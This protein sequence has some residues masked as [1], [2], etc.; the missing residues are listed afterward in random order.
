VKP[1]KLSLSE[2]LYRKRIALEELSSKLSR[3]SIVK[4]RND[5]HARRLPRPCGITVHVALGCTY[6]CAYCYV[7]DMGFS[8]R[9]Y[10]LYGLNGEELAYAL[11]SNK[12]FLPGRLG[13]FIAI[14]SVGEP[15]GDDALFSKT[16][17]YLNSI[18]R[19][20]GNPTQIS[21][22]AYL[23]EEKAKRLARVEMPLSILVTIVT[24]GKH[25]RLEPG[26]PEPWK[27]L[28]TIRRLRKAGA[29]P[30]L[31]LR[32]LIPG[33]NDDE[34]ED[35]IREASRHGAYGVVVGGF[36]ASPSILARLR[37]AGFDVSAIMERLRG[38][39][40]RGRQ[41]PV[42]TRDLKEAAVSYAR[43]RGIVPFLSACCANNYA[44]FLAT[45]Q[46]VPCA[47]LDYIEG[48]FCT[49]CP[50]LCEE[51]PVEVDVEEAARHVKR[52]T[53]TSDLEVDDD[54]FYLRLRGNDAERAY[55][56]LRGWKRIILE[57]GYR[58]RVS[59]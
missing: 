17:E 2:L 11:L 27:R 6:R 28:Q 53:S 23:D 52:L 59:L 9:E 29:R 43:R 58:H 41:T 18:G 33:V 36:R 47:G 39:L 48:R 38:S 1:L 31:F 32:P 46:R 49:R 3:E 10:R 54:G 7:P 24:L 44:A 26:A 34:V 8:F 30:F 37:G 51:I 45:G 55:K 57:T 4:A 40:A 15:L 42:Y 35:I 19:H 14:G 22:K 13:T 56:R 5:H 16:V 12:A 20:L 21:T 25:E 50:V